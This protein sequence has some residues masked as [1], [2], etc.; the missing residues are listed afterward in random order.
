[1]MVLASITCTGIISADMSA[2][3]TDIDIICSDESSV[4]NLMEQYRTCV[5]IQFHLCIRCL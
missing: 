3:T 1:M 2:D 5:S 4:S